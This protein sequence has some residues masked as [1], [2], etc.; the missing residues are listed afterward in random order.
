MCRRLEGTVKKRTLQ[1]QEATRRLGE[2]KTSVEL[3]R[4]ITAASRE[5]AVS[6]TLETAIHQICRY[7]DYP[8]GHVYVLSGAEDKLISGDLWY[9]RYPRRFEA[10]RRAS[11]T[12]SFSRGEGI[13]GRVL[14]G[15]RPLWIVDVTRD[16]NFKRSKAA[17]E[18]GIRGALFFPVLIRNKVEAVLEFFTPLKARP[19]ERLLETMGYLG[20]QLGC[21]MER[22]RL[23]RALEE[24]NTALQ[25]VLKQ[26]EA[27]KKRI[28]DNVVSN[29]ENLL[30]PL[31]GK[32]KRRGTPDDRR[33]VGLLEE[34]LKHL[35]AAFGVRISEK[36]WKLTSREK[37]IC[38]MI[39]SGLAT[40]EI[41]RLMNISLRTIEIHRR[42]IRRKLGL[43]HKKVNLI[44][45]LQSF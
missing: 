34:N 10:L 19:S 41:A 5:C 23:C 36:K 1:L 14:A 2:E 40:K 8:V 21:I 37:E 24:K 42:H 22:D 39:R 33:Y 29:V 25:E 3:H 35:T 45:Y 16:R 17:A 20:V 11:M 7:M 15:G 4:L 26:I 28:K 9:S 43:T 6:K 13:P 32:L 38:S 30:L 31:L 27:E 12:V 44:S 18:S